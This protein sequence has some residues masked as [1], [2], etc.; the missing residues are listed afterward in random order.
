M[1]LLEENQ[2]AEQISSWKEIIQSFSEG[3]FDSTNLLHIELEY[4]N[5][6]KTVTDPRISGYI[7]TGITYQNYL[8]IYNTSENQAEHFSD[9]DNFEIECA[10]EEAKKLRDFIFELQNLAESMGKELWVVPNLSY[11]YFPVS[12][13]AGDLME[14]GINV[15]FGLKV[16]STE[17]HENREVFNKS[18][19]K[20]M[21]HEIVDKQPLIVVVD[22][23]QHLTQREN[24]SPRYPDAYQG[25]LNQIIALNDA[26]GFID[27]DYSY[28]GKT[29]ED[30]EKLRQKSDFQELVQIFKNSNIQNTNST[31]YKFNFWNTAELDLVIRGNRQEL[32]ATNDTSSNSTE[33]NNMFFCNVGLLDN[34][35]PSEIKVKYPN[36]IHT[37]AFFD[38]SGRIVK[39]SFY[40]DQY[41]IH[42]S[43]AL[44]KE[45]KRVY[46]R[47]QTN[48]FNVIECHLIDIIR[49]GLINQPVRTEI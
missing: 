15:V 35:I 8:N 48:S 7:K 39:L 47:D 45:A 21:R 20:G 44:E 38:D 30:I 9:Q 14:S 40:H 46:Y 37:P 33:G 17:S 10:I 16:G 4:T 29:P 36:L 32:G 49:K 27:E 5:F 42:Y 26:L 22:G 24:K 12:P 1:E 28:T 43:N 31:P 19:F 3:K 23:T 41:G 18:L 2:S 34:Q 25:Y 13:I 11:G 6:T